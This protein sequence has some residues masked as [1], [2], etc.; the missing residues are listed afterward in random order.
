MEFLDRKEIGE[1]LRRIRKEKGWSIENISKMNNNISQTTISNIERGVPSVGNEFIEE[2]CTFLGIPHGKLPSLLQIEN[3][4]RE[5]I[6]KKLIRIENMI[7][8]I[9]ANSAFKKLKK[10][11]IPNDNHL[12]IIYFHLEGRCLYYKRQYEKA[13]TRFGSALKLLNKHPELEFTNLRASC[14]CELGRISFYHH[15]DLKQALQYSELGLKAFQSNGLRQFI[16]LSLLSGKASY[17]EMMHQDED[18]L[19][20]VEELLNEKHWHKGLDAIL[21]GI[22][23]KS[24]LSAKRG[25]YQEALDFATEGIE[26]ARL[27]RHYSRALELLTAMGNICFLMDDYEEAEDWYL[28]AIELG[29]KI[30]QKYLL[31]STHNQLGKLY[32]ALSNWEQAYHHLHKAVEI[33]AKNDDG[34]RYYSSLVSFGDFYIRTYQAHSAIQHLETARKLSEKNNFPAVEPELFLRLSHCYEGT[35]VVKSQKYLARYKSSKLKF[36]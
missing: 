12:Q 17:L 2:Y 30:N 28:C 23:I 14:Y 13:S 15:N 6:H 18:A 9:E 8:L 36:N 29:Q 27:N 35:D 1:I 11:N 16:K 3:I 34:I 20:T 32:M 25:Y 31:V 19:V 22:E 10:I 33:G 7:N 5:T 4:Q 26:L 24:Q 21:N